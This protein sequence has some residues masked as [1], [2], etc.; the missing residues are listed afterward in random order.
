MGITFRVE[1]FLERYSRYN[2][3]F[4]LLPVIV[5]IAAFFIT[6][7]FILFRFSLHREDP[8]LAYVPDFTFDSYL[9]FLKDP[10]Y[11][12]LIVQNIKL[13]IV[14]SILTLLLGYP[15]AYSAW[16]ARG[17]KKTVLIFFIIFP[18]FVN[19]VIRLYGWL[20]IL[21][22]L[23]PISYILRALN[24][25]SEPTSFGYSFT[26]VV[27]GLT[28]ECLPYL[29]LTLLPVLEGIDWS[30]VESARDLGAGKLRSFYEIIFPL[31]M[32]GMAAGTA[33]TLIWS[34]GAFVTPTILGSARERTLAMEAEDQIRRTLNWPFGAA[35]SFILVLVLLLILIVYYKFSAGRRVVQ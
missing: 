32:P 3:L 27:I 5:L 28:T 20:I 19:L 29:I 34:I 17:K 23:G 30:L 31:S 33:L 1:K 6:P 21:G 18:L 10:W 16:R 4:L 26:A 12:N 15:V 14:V 25:I 7:V 2:Y 35:V 24:L 9:R 11:L 13:A 8:I 22:R